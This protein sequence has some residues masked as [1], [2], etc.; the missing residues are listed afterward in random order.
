MGPE[1]WDEVVDVEVAGR[2]N[3]SYVTAGDARGGDRS[4]M[5]DIRTNGGRIVSRVPLKHSIL[6]LEDEIDVRTWTQRSKDGRT[7]PID[8]LNELAVSDN[9]V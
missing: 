2:G 7:D 1:E 3:D 6:R 4:G 9:G 8:S 5:V